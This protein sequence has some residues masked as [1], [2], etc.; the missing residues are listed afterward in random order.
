MWD[1][2]GLH[3]I[4]DKV[5]GGEGGGIKDGVS[6]VLDEGKGGDL[7]THWQTDR[8]TDSCGPL[9]ARVQPWWSVVIKGIG[10]FV[11]VLFVFCVFFDWE[12]NYMDFP[13][14][15]VHSNVCW[16]HGSTIVI[17]F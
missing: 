1:L 7:S 12:L 9:L 3:L 2:F 4:G 5:Q 17:S 13:S 14:I 15:T 10:V 11:S 6:W 16:Q 8:V